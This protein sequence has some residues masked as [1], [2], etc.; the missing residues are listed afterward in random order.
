MK[1]K[2]YRA[3]DVNRIDLT[4]LLQRHPEQTVTVGLDMGK[5]E[6]RCVL[7][8][9]HD[10]YERP[11]RVTNPWQVRL[12]ATLLA[13][14]GQDRHLVVALEPTGTY[15]EPVRQAL[16]EAGV[17]LWRVSPKMTSDYA[18]IF[19][20]VPSQHDGKDAALIAELAAQHKCWPWPYAPATEAEQELVYWVERLD[21][22]RQQKQVQCGRLEALLARHW[23]E[24][25][26]TLA[27]TSATL[28]RCLAHY[29]SPA[30]LAADPDGVARL[31]RWGGTYLPRAKAEALWTNAA[32]T[33][34]VRLGHWDT[35]RLQQ[36]AEA[37]VAQQQAHRAGAR[38]LQALAK[39]N[40]VLTAQA[41][42]V[43]PVT[44]SVLWLHL[45]DPR[46][47]YCGAAYR[48]A[49]GLNLAER[50]SGKYQGQVKLSKRGSAQVRRWLYLAA[51]RWVKEEPVH[52]WYVQ[53]KQQRRGEGKAVVIALM[54]KLAVALYQVA[55]GQPFDAAR[56]GA[57]VVEALA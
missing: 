5:E 7:R 40:A 23:P 28:L 36:T 34:G 6:I 42:V 8:W 3:L 32:Q 41:D 54:R 29:G 33:V 57:S 26:R 30:A 47:Y 55:A 53:R 24:A 19:D 11:W 43:G 48:K 25:T 50:S 27:L 46:D 17:P 12:L 56:L 13:Q 2:A 37:I 10:D 22:A 51:L 21:A 45:G 35:V 16:H 15:G 31:C 49:M 20:G 1:S 39:D 52:S 9:S 14:L 18:E 38:R 44:A 4:A